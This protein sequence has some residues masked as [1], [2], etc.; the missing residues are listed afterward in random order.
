[1]PIVFAATG[2]VI[3]TPEHP[4]VARGD[5][6]HLIVYPKVTVEDRTQLT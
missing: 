5:G 2:F 1:M 6:G 3:S 4:D